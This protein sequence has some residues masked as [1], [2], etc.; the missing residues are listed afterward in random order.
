M[1]LRGYFY[2]RRGRNLA[3]LTGVAALAILLAVLALNHRAAVVAPKY[4]EQTFL[5]GLAHALNAGE[6]THIRIQSKQKSFEVAF[7]PVKGW[8]LPDNDNYPASF[9]MV[10]QTLV[11]LAA[12]QTVEPKTG[13][14]ELY[15]YVG[16]DAPPK[17]NGVS[18]T[19]SND[20]GKVLAA[21]IIG[22]SEALGN[23]AGFF[24]R[25]AGEKQSWLVKSPSD[26]K[27][28]PADWMDKNVVAVDRTRVASI[29][30][31]P[32]SGPAYTISRATPG[33]ESF[34]VA[35]LPKGRELAYAGAADGVASAL[36]DFSFDDIAHSIDFDFNSSA[37]MTVRAFDGLL[38]T[39]NVVVKDGASW[40]RIFAEAEPGKRKAA[41]EA[42]AINAKTAGW[43]FKLPGFKASLF[44]QPL[45][46]LLKPQAK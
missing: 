32:I 24:V 34:S 31:E 11:A 17:G 9:A 28:S 19:L 42:L 7:V 33:E 44:A 2:H 23:E 46:T 45:E 18:V 30:V 35:P 36:S 41:K 15:S 3:A 37:K 1:T 43:A 21:L 22:K 29:T 6:V 40:V 20:K 14:P 13:N 27:T 4:E 38:V 25:K 16:L 26:I 5:P 8:V 39:V 10:K 12:L